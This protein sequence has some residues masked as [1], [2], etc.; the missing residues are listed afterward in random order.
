M[1]TFRDDDREAAG[2]L[3]VRAERSA[4]FAF[5]ARSSTARMIA[6]ECE[7]SRKVRGGIVLVAML[8]TSAVW[9]H[10]PDISAR[11]LLSGWK[12]QD[13][14]MRMLAEVIASAFFKRPLLA[15]FPCGKG[16]LLPAARLERA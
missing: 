14:S 2:S 11:R 4:G 12:E 1:R 8:L 5:L 10:S 7:G 15:R 13:P 9:A 3:P 16:N 6:D